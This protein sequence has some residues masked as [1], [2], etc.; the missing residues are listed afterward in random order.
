MAEWVLAGK[1]MEIPVDEL[2]IEPVVVGDEHR[3]RKH[4]CLQPAAKISDYFFGSVKPQHFVPCEAADGKRFRNPLL[5]NRTDLPVKC[6][7][8]GWSDKHGAKADHRVI[9]GNWAV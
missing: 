9:A 3:A 6:F 4:V 1:M 8:K 7:V 5:G 2:P